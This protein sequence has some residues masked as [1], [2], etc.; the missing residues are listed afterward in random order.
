MN[1]WTT[2]ICRRGESQRAFSIVGVELD[3]IRACGQTSTDTRPHARDAVARV[4]DPG[5]GGSSDGVFLSDFVAARR[6]ET[7]RR[8]EDP[9]TGDQTAIHSVSDVDV[10]VLGAFGS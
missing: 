3:D 10:G 7:F 5:S 9:G 8:A 4:R 2:G 1:V 6:C